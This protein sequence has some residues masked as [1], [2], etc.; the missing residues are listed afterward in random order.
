VIT[1]RN[2]SEIL[3]RICSRPGACEKQPVLVIAEIGVNHDGSLK[4]ALDLVD[5][6][7][8]CGA[9]AVKLQLFRADTLMHASS[10][11]AGYQHERVTD[12]DPTAMLRR[13]ELGAADV[14]EVVAAI[15][16]RGLLPIA[17]PFSPADVDV[18]AKVKLPAVKIASP[19]L[20][21]Y[22]LLARAAKLSVPLIIS[23]GAATMEEVAQ[24]CAWLREWRATA[25]LLH[26]VSSYPT[27]AAQANLC[28]I[29]EMSQRFG[30]PMGYSDHTTEI[31][32]GALAVAAGAVII[33]K[34]LT[35]DRAAEGPDHSASADRKQ[36]TEYVRLVRQAQLLRGA[37]GK[38]VLDV[39]Q[40][41]RRVSR[42]SLV[43]MRDVPVGEILNDDDLTVQRPGTGIAAAHVAAV[44]GRRAARKIPR[45]AMLAWDMLA[46]AA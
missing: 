6:A 45:G 20:V 10:Q 15:R 30:L 32:A 13:F 7:A 19:D 44:V 1:V 31:M 36:F 40:D 41:V 2:E 17:T 5:I 29:A 28:W 34:H 4:R 11:F 26:C 3:G 21:N 8:A 33:E 18:I 9:D 25:A 24:T 38:R 14:R 22:P 12:A 39:E 46:D 27:P 43:A 16:R 23:T 35:Y 37:A 42:Q